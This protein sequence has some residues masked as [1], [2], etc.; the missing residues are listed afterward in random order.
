MAKEFSLREQ[1]RLNEAH[2]LNEHEELIGMQ[3]NFP[4]TQPEIKK[5]II[6]EF[7]PQAKFI[8]LP[9]VNLS[10]YIGHRKNSVH[11]IKISSEKLSPF[12]SDPEIESIECPGPDA[13]ISIK[14]RGEIISTSV[15]MSESEISNL[16][17]E[18]S[19]LTNTQIIDGILSVS[20]PEMSFTA[21]LSEFVGSRFIIQKN[22]F[23]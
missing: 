16:V 15:K 10:P 20:I 5:I 2:M 19:K 6:K 8:A 21:V 9:P 11:N 14:K 22:S 3:N 13:P 23:R 12:I 7:N 18:I 1:Y 4:K 17:K